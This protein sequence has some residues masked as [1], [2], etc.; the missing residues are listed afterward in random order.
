MIQTIDGQRE[1]DIHI[2]KLLGLQ[3]DLIEGTKRW[4]MGEPADDLSTLRHEAICLNHLRYV[5]LVPAY[6]KFAES[7]D[8]LGNVDLNLVI[9]ELM[10]T[11]DL[12]K[13]YDSTLLDQAD[14]AGMNAWLSNI[15][16][17]DICFD[18][19]A[20][21][22]VAQWRTHLKAAGIF[23][24]YSSGTSGNM[25]FI[26][27][28]PMTWGA[29][30][31]NSS[32]YAN[33]N[34][35]IR[36]DGQTPS[37]DCLIAGPRGEG[38]GIQGAA[39]GLS[40]MAANAHYLYDK[41]LNEDAVR[42]QLTPKI[43]ELDERQAYESA[44][45]FINAARDGNRPVLVFG[46]PFQLR[47]FCERLTEL[48]AKLDTLPGSTVVT[49]GGWKSFQ[50]ERIPQTDLIDMVDQTLHIP[51]SH[52]IDTYSTA[53]LNCAMTRCAE[54]HYHIPPLIE[55]VL[56]DESL[57]GECGAT[58]YG[59]LGFLDPFSMSFPGY[60]ITGDMGKLEN[61]LC[62]CGL[63]GWYIDGEIKRAPEQSI[64]GC[65]GVLASMTA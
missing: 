14:F 49:G 44:I 63:H 30:R 38:M 53:E 48:Q 50:G 5:N 27:R 15:C 32:Y 39:A 28:D 16:T 59:T 58:G 56:L 12:F 26:P 51:S 62:G 19:S 61:T 52:F 13:S 47:R 21:H 40:A 36:M 10:F 55:P 11:D 3:A 7:V 34:S 46:A 31:K 33:P 17:Q 35:I 1:P 23:L 37:F 2:G 24:S 54:G 9:N 20:V 6:H 57:F 65:G 25:S 43:T 18:T 4:A 29:L 22:N 41:V 42:N 64:K 45:A 8:L 60:L